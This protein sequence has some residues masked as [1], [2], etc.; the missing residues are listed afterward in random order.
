[1]GVEFTLTVALG[2]EMGDVKKVVI[3]KRIPGGEDGLS[4]SLT[5]HL[6]TSV[7]DEREKRIWAALALLLRELM[8]EEEMEEFK[9]QIEAHQAAIKAEAKK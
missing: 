4:V 8:T 6:E 7:D 9:R 3:V 5:F 1:M 2:E